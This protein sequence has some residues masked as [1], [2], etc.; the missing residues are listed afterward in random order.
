[1]SIWCTKLKR[2][3]SGRVKRILEEGLLSSY[4]IIYQFSEAEFSCASR[5]T[6]F[7]VLSVFVAHMTFS[8]LVTNQTLQTAQTNGRKMDLSES[9]RTWSLAKAR[10][11][12]QTGLP[13]Q[14]YYYYDYHTK[15]LADQIAVSFAAHREMHFV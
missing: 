14:Q 3:Q 1:M 2:N 12:G 10:I 13:M 9:R 15:P 5:K 6:L 7:V 11:A 8:L 4:M